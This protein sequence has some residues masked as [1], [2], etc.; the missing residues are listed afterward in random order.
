MRTFGNDYKYQLKKYG[1]FRFIDE[2]IQQQSLEVVKIIYKKIKN[3]YSTV[4]LGKI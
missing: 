3:F 1:L 2:T 4:K